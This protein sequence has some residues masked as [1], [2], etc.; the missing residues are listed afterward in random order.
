[1]QAVLILGC[2]KTVLILYRPL[3]RVKDVMSSV[4]LAERQLRD[5]S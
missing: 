2:Y 1:M 5:L 3:S 4:S